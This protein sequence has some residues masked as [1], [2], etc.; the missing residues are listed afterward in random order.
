[1]KQKLL[2]AREVA[3]MLGWHVITVYR[4][5]RELKIPSIKIGYSLR[6]REEHIERMLKDGEVG[7]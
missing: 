2:T 3:D 1:M 5:A 4:K 6:F 7:T